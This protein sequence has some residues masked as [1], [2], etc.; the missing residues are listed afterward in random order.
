VNVTVPQPN[1]ID[2]LQGLAA[3]D[4][5]KHQAR[6]IVSDPSGGNDTAQITGIDRRVFG[7]RVHVSIQR[8]GWT[9][10]DGAAYTPLDISE[11][12]YPVSDNSI[13]VSTTTA[14]C[15]ICPVMPGSP[16]VSEA[17]LPALR[18]KPTGSR[19]LYPPIGDMRRRFRAHSRYLKR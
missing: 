4:T 7:N 16:E 17:G 14:P 8:V 12:D 11:S 2:T 9:G 5:G 6:I 10:Y 18:M 3:L 1:T 13:S 19:P 15:P